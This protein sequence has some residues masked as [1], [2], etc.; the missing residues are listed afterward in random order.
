MKMKRDSCLAS[1]RSRRKLVSALLSAKL[2]AQFDTFVQ[3][4]LKQVKHISVQV[5]KH[6]YIISPVG[7]LLCLRSDREDVAN[8]ASLRN[9]EQKAEISRLTEELNATKSKNKVQI[10]QPKVSSA[11]ENFGAAPGI[12]DKTAALGAMP[13]PLCYEP[14]TKV[15]E[16]LINPFRYIVASHDVEL[17]LPVEV[18]LGVVPSRL[19]PKPVLSMFDLKASSGFFC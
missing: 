14:V 17:E 1:K 11:L 19:R 4:K 5:L 3:F 16:V 2:D 15:F 18:K 8:S 9:V 7:R 10:V 13:K 12:L 6:L